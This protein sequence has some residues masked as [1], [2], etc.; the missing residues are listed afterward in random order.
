MV[1]VVVAVAAEAVA[2]LVVVQLV[3]P[4]HVQEFLM[5]N[6]LQTQGVNVHCL[7]G[8]GLSTRATVDILCFQPAMHFCL[9]RNA[10]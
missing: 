9:P 8:L 4:H 5:A 1:L 7:D 6:S 3:A 10:P 2:V